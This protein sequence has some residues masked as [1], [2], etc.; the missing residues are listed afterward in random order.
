MSMPLVHIV[1]FLLTVEHF[2]WFFITYILHFRMHVL[3][4]PLPWKLYLVKSLM[5][6]MYFWC[7]HYFICTFFYIY[8]KKYHS[9]THC[10]VLPLH[11]IYVFKSQH[12]RLITLLDNSISSKQMNHHE[13]KKINF[14][15]IFAITQKIKIG[16]IF[17]DFSHSI[18]HIPHL[19]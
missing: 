14:K 3:K 11:L 15:W 12:R 8:C 1:V 18:Q 19:S 10:F 5:L 16:R 17:Y 9:M 6:R 2:C 4:F 7:V 13:Q